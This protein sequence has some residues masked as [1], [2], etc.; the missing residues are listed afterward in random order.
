M[1]WMKRYLAPT[2][3]G[4]VASG[5]LVA[6]HTAG[7]SRWEWGGFGMYSELPPATRHVD[8]DLEKPAEELDGKIGAQIEEATVRLA[9]LPSRDR[10][11][12][13]A[14]VLREA[15]MRRFRI[16]AWAEKLELDALVITR[17]ELW[18]LTV[19]EQATP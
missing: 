16:E 13:I 17:E 9:T 8:I 12:A 2:L 18:Q 14:D 15:G 10:F 7:L 5:Q 11:E 3:L 6:V 1:D 4:V 19:G